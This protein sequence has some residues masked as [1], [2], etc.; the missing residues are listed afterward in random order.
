MYRRNETQSG[1][2]TERATFA[3]FILI[4]FAACALFAPD[5][6]RAQPNPAPGYSVSVFARGGGATGYTQPDS[7]AIDRGNVF[8][9]YGNGVAKDGSDGKSSTIVEY[10][11]GGQYERQFS[12]VGHNDGL[13]FDPATHLLWAIQNEDGNPNLAI[14]NPMTGSRLNYT[15]GSVNGGGGFDDVVFRNGQAYLSASNPAKNPNSDPAIVTATILGSVV[16]T[17][18][19]L[20]GNA[21]ARDIATGL[22]TTLN[23]QDPDSMTLTPK[24]SLLLSSQDDARLVSVN[25]PGA[26]QTVETLALT[27]AGA[28]AKVDDTVFAAPSGSILVSDLATNTVYDITGPLTSGGAYTAGINQS[29][30]DGFVGS[31]NQATGKITPIVTGLINPRG[32]AALSIPEPS[33]VI[34][35]A[36]GVLGV[37]GCSLLHRPKS[38][39]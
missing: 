1:P 30:N 21:T 23:L 19:V 34:A 4:P 14:I 11:T 7:I 25:N 16:A 37:V 18:P 13:R 35:L 39:A 29:T 22:Q 36:T 6:A 10:T 2:A 3:R 28:T 24:G 9:G 5:T 17:S 8:I 32:M 38:T 20:L 26:G 27:S 15:L 31:L 33:S 12:V